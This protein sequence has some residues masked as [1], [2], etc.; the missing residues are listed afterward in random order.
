MNHAVG[1]QFRSHR[2]QYPNKFQNRTAQH[3][4]T[5]KWLKLIESVHVPVPKRTKRSR[6]TGRTIRFQTAQNTAQSHGLSEYRSVGPRWSWVIYPRA[7]VPSPQVRWLN[8]PG[9][10]PP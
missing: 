3:R 6:P 7:P 10:H 8:P 5:L 9:T 4:L 2:L 1:L